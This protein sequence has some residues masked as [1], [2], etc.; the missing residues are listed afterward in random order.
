[1]SSANEI[2]NKKRSTSRACCGMPGNKCWHFLHTTWQCWPAHPKIKSKALLWSERRSRAVFRFCSWPHEHLETSVA[3]GHDLL[4]LSWKCWN[5]IE[6]TEPLPNPG[7][8]DRPPFGCVGYRVLQNNCCS[9]RCEIFKAQECFF[10][11]MKH[12]SR[13]CIVVG[14]KLHPICCKNKVVVSQRK[15]TSAPQFCICA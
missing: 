5:Q 9:P 6:T 12:S 15:Q 10:H 3:T 7:K 4:W 11:L 1:M 13:I 8:R 14:L 2:L